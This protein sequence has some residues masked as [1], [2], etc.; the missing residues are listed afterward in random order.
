MPHEVKLRNFAKKDKNGRGWFGLFG[1]SKQ[2]QEN[3]CNNTAEYCDDLGLNVPGQREIEINHRIEFY[4]YTE[5]EQLWTNKAYRFERSLKTE[6]VTLREHAD[7]IRRKYLEKRNSGRPGLTAD[8]GEVA[9]EQTDQD[10]FSE[11]SMTLEN[12]VLSPD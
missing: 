8:Y 10:E 5:I 4:N 7:E 3:S 2:K 12:F 6:D 11:V 9:E 1:K